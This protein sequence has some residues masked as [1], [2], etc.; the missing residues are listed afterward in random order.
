MENLKAYVESRN[1]WAAIFNGKQLSLKSAA[2]RQRIA[3]MIDADLSPENLTCDGELPAAQVRARHKALMTVA[4]EL[5]A[6]DPTV[7]FYDYN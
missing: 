5:K 4:I 3:E 7:K 2:D 1:K 6:F